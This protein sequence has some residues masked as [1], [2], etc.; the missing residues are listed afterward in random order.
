[1]YVVDK[2]RRELP[3]SGKSESMKKDKDGAL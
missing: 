2:R 3:T 1:M